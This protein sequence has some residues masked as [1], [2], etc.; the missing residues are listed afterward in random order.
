[1]RRC[2]CPTA[3]CA[4]PARWGDRHFAVWDD[5]LPKPSYLFALVGGD[6]G[7]CRRHFTTAVR[8][9]GRSADLCR[10]RQGGPLRLRDGCAEAID[11]AGTRRALA[12][13]TISTFSISS[14]CPTSTWARWRT[15][16]SMSSTTKYV[17]ASPETATD[18][19]YRARSKPSSRTSIS[20][21][22]PATASPA[23]T[24]SSSA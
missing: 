24:G 19:D 10:A 20:T 18:A 5:P 16:G 7:C 2:C 21:T 15:R 23:A 13:N 3:I 12:A 4:E 11:D 8:P 6:L 1:M 22:G 14:P 9:Q 17:L